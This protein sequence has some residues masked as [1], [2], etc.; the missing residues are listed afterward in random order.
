M[1]RFGVVLIALFGIF[2]SIAFPRLDTSEESLLDTE[3]KIGKKSVFCRKDSTPT[4]LFILGKKKEIPLN[5]YVKRLIRKKRKLGGDSWKKLRR[6]LNRQKRKR[7]GAIDCSSPDVVPT[8]IPPTPVPTQPPSEESCELTVTEL[9]LTL[10]QE[11]ERAV[12]LEYQTNCSNP[13]V[14]RI[15]SGGDF[16]TTTQNGS[17]VDITA[18]SLIVTES[19]LIE[20][21]AE[22][23]EGNVSAVD[24]ASLILKTNPKKTVVTVRDHEFMPSTVTVLEGDSVLWSWIDDFHDVVAGNDPDSTTGAFDSGILNAGASFEVQFG[25]ELLKSYRVNNNTYDYICNPHYAMGMVGEVIVQKRPHYFEASPSLFQEDGMSSNNPVADCTLEYIDGELTGTCAYSGDYTS[26]TV[27]SGD[28]GETGI[29]LCDTI[30]ISTGAN[31]SC[32]FVLALENNLFDGTFYLTLEGQDPTSKGQVVLFGGGQEIT[33]RVWDE[34][35]EGIEGVVVTG[36]GR[37]AVTD[38]FGRYTIHGVPNGVHILTA[39]REGFTITA[40]PFVSPVIMNGSDLSLR[41]FTAFENS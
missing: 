34:D 30:P 17:E 7:F 10:E 23:G 16:F 36:A 6:K 3:L 8:P 4:E 31:F 9:S 28:Y 5:R 33:G 19:V 41:T 2:F 21:R 35:L 32:T 18:P 12:S 25:K 1:K 37:S 15:I 13:I 11:E 27:G 14:F 22:D 38:E 26:L 40:D 24:R 29:T 20:G 39:K